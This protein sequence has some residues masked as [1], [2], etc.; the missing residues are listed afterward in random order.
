MSASRRDF[1]L[2]SITGIPI[3]YAEI[4]SV[5]ELQYYAIVFRASK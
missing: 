2:K 1:V 3:Q 4:S 5:M